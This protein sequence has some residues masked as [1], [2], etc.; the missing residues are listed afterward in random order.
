MEKILGFPIIPLINNMTGSADTKMEG[1]GEVLSHDSANPPT[2]DKEEPKDKI[3][4]VR[5]IKHWVH[6]EGKLI[7]EKG[8]RI[9]AVFGATNKEYSE[10]DLKQAFK[11]GFLQFLDYFFTY[12]V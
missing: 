1:Q 12:M 3:V 8:G 9:Y 4:A 7:K 5:K 6:G 11:R 10:D 2:S